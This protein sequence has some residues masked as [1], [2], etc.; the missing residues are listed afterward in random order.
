MTNPQKTI[1][2]GDTPLKRT[3]KVVRGLYVDLLG[4]SF[5]KI[6][7]SDAMEPFFMTIVSSS[8]HW[9]FISSNGGLTA[10]RGNADQALFPYTTEDKLTDTHETTGSKT[11]LLVT[12][13][14]RTCLWEPLSDRQQGQY[15]VTRNLYK[16]IS[17]TALIFEEV[18]HDLGLTYRYAWRTSDRFGFIKTTWLVN[19]GESAC[20]VELLDGLQNILPANVTEQTQNTFSPLLDAYKRSEVDPKTGLALFYLN[21]RLTDKAEP[22]ESLLATSVAQI[23]LPQADY[24]LSSTQLDR[25]RNGKGI[26]PETNIRGRRGAYFVHATLDLAPQEECSWY[27]IADINQ[28]SAAI[29]R[30]S[31]WLRGD[32][33]KLIQD[34]E[35]DIA[36]GQSNLW[37]MV[38]SADGLQLSNDRLCS[39]HHFANVMFNIM[40]G[41]IFADQYWIKSAEFIGFVIRAGSSAPGNS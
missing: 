1:F 14:G 20:Q 9:L 39:D 4:E 7:N 16:N 25:F 3:E 40:R 34:L 18:N 11:I 38:A 2:A 30:H 35:N 24:L 28:D 37:K 12:R 36:A 22:S 32:R 19:T 13:S 26:V 31:Q 21:S 8:D 15:T 33:G 41:G 6:E 23:G 5:Y 29:A 10:G 27:L 17:G